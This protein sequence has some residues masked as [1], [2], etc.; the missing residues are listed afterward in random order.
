MDKG[1]HGNGFKDWR[2]RAKERKKLAGTIKGPGVNVIEGGKPDSY[3][4]F[5]KSLMTDA[6][7]KEIDARLNRLIAE[8]SYE[9]HCNDHDLSE[10]IKPLLDQSK[11]GT[12]DAPA[13]ST[14]SFPVAENPPKWVVG[15]FG[16]VWTDLS[17]DSQLYRVHYVGG[18]D[19][20]VEED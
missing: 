5:Q 18:N 6:K 2:E 7:H 17:I 12:N 8:K 11:V 10:K 15:M 16:S 1:K 3:E 13:L 20:V 14:A 19:F 9:L 4:K